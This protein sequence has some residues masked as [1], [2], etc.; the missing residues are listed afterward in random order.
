M[1]LLLTA[2]P[3]VPVPPK[4][5][6]GIERI[7][8]GLIR[9]FRKRGHEVGLVAHSASCEPIDYFCGWR[10]ETPSGPQAHAQ[11]AVCL[12]QAFREFKPV[13]VHSFSRILYLSALLRLRT[14]KVM[15]Y[16]RM[17]AK[18]TV[19]LGAFLGGRSLVFTGCSEFIA[20]IGGAHGGRWHAIPNFVDTAAYEFSLTVPSDAPLVFLS[21]VEP[22]KGAHWAIEVARRTGRRL[23]IAGNYAAS[24]RDREYWDNVIQPQLGKNGVEYIGPVDDPAKIRLLNSAAAMIVPIQWDEPFGIV[25]AEALACGTPVISCPR[26][27]LPEIVREGIDGFLVRNVDEA[28]RAVEAL[29]QIDRGAC[30]KRAETSFSASGVSRRYETLYESLI[31]MA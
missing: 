12:L 26:G 15:S 11:N 16:Q 2:D 8:A 22:I 25:F 31:A 20:S 21:R 9:E 19:K 24:G 23:V 18:H 10:R 7:V 29:D 1:R 13:L 30:R 14:P 4:Y 3:F 17:V 28:C 6:G 27:A 5:Y